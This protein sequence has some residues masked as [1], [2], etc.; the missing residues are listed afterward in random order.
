MSADYWLEI[1]T[2]GPEPVQITDP[3]FNV[4]YNLGPML[5]AAGFPDWK[6]LRGMTAADAGQVLTGVAE[7][8]LMDRVRL[9]RDFSPANGWGDWNCA[10][11][12]VT[13]FRAA[14]LAHPKAVV[15]AWL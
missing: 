2:G 10:Y 6:E 15:A 5:R 13:E 9:E 12:F 7:L 3:S 8:L 4:T 11:E 1:D 14:C